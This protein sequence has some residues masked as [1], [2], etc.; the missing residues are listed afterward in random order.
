MRFYHD[1]Q[2]DEPRSTAARFSWCCL[3]SGSATHYRRFASKFAKSEVS[4]LISLPKSYETDSAKRYPVVYWL[5]GM[6]GN[7]RAGVSFLRQ[8]IPV[9]ESGRSPE[10][11]VVLVNGM[12]DCFYND[13]PHGKWP[14][15]SVLMKELIPHIDETYR[16]LAK[17]ESRAVEGYSMG[18]Y[19]AAHLA[20]N[21]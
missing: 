21:C 2:N 19:G 11:I 20:F 5:H 12:K 3:A 9:M 7:Q 17:R 10:M 15:E 16:T 1:Y 4:Y 14:V 18:G 6:G 8:A 13:S